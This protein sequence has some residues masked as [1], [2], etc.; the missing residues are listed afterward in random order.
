V[1]KFQKSVAVYGFQS[2]SRIKKYFILD[3]SLTS[4]DSKYKFIPSLYDLTLFQV[5]EAATASQAAWEIHRAAS[6]E[7]EQKQKAVQVFFKKINK[8]I[9]KSR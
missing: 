9:M 5:M 8:H 1:I 7:F 3:R 2:L 4:N 6:I